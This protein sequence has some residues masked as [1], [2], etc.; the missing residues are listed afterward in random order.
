MRFYRHQISLFAVVAV[1]T[2]VPSLA[3]TLTSESCAQESMAL[4]GHR[5]LEEAA[6]QRAERRG[7]LGL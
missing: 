1:A 7:A 2:F 4:I 3:S 6:E 5:A